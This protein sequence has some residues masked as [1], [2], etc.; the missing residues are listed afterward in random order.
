MAQKNI[1]LV[2]R[3]I[4]ADFDAVS[5]LCAD[6]TVKD[7]AD[8]VRLLSTVLAAE[9]TAELGPEHASKMTASWSAEAIAGERGALPMVADLRSTRVIDRSY[10]SVADQAEQRDLHQ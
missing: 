9:I 3:I 6:L 5:A 7:F 2:E 1:S 8:L 10:V 4:L